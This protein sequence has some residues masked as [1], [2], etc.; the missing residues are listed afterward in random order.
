MCNHCSLDPRDELATGALALLGLRDLVYEV[1]QAG[2][3][4]FDVVEPAGLAEL[5]DMVHMRIE[6][7]S[8]RLQGYVPRD[9][10]PPST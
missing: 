2:K 3:C 7:A 5:L 10:T 8:M 4:G 1:S 9:W 6:G